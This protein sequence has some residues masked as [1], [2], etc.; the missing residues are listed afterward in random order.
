MDQML[1]QDLHVDLP[2]VEVAAFFKAELPRCVDTVRRGRMVERMDGSLTVEKARRNRLETFVLRGMVE[3]GLREQMAPERLE[4]LDAIERE[5]AQD[6]Q[7]KMFREF[8]SPAFNSEIQ[9]RAKA[10]S[11][12]TQMDVLQ[13]RWAAVEARMA[14]HEAAEAVPLHNA[15]SVRD[16]AVALLRGITQ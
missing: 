4:R 8:I 10:G 11:S 2:A 16:A 1:D 7:S 9:K 12:L 15:E 5:T 3:D 13:L 14:A 6:T